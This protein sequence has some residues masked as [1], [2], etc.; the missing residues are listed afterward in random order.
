MNLKTPRHSVIVSYLKTQATPRSTLE[1]AEALNI[2]NANA[3]NRVRQLYDSGR[4]KPC[5]EAQKIDFA[6]W[7]PTDGVNFDAVD[8]DVETGTKA[9]RSLKAMQAM[10]AA[11]LAAGRLADWKRDE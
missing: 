2:S 5:K 8:H 3:R 4:I 11:R 7:T 1:I 9:E 6:T 10:C